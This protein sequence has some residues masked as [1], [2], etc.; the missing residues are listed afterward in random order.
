MVIAHALLQLWV[1]DPRCSAFPPLCTRN[2]YGTL[3]V[4]FIRY[5]SSIYMHDDMRN[6]RFA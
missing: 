6:A 4:L 2:T 1:G 5:F 3:L